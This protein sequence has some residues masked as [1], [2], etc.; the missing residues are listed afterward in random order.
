MLSQG[1]VSSGG[2]SRT[3]SRSP[4]SR[5]HGDIQRC[6]AA[7]KREQEGE[8]ESFPGGDER[9]SR[10]GDTHLWTLGTLAGPGNFRIHDSEQGKIILLTSSS[11]TV[12]W[13]SFFFGVSLLYLASEAIPVEHFTGKWLDITHS[14]QAWRH[15]LSAQQK[16]ILSY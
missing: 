5:A 10:E 9:S 14:C 3:A 4:A 6:E 15:P 8:F 12:W 13:L 1:T 2:A 11:F 7:H 16:H